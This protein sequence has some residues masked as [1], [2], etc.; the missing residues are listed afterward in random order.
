MIRVI[1]IVKLIGNVIHKLI[2]ASITIVYQQIEDNLIVSS[3]IFTKR[4]ENGINMPF[5]SI[6]GGI[7]E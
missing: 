2:L 3:W 1:R 4:V 5:L 7:E 6:C